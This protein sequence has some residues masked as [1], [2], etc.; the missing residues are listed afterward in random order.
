M[1]LA[2]ER[3]LRLA[4]R[5]GGSLVR[6]LFPLEIKATLEEAPGGC[7]VEA[8]PTGFRLV[9]VQGLDSLDT[10]SLVMGLL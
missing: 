2:A 3:L 5:G 7:A 1:V 6:G 9:L 8:A 10:L 4:H